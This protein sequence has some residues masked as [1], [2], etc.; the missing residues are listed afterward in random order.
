[1]E[2]AFLVYRLPPYHRSWNKRVV[3]QPKL[4][5]LD[6][7]VLCALLNIRTEQ[8][9]RTH[10]L[11]GHIFESWVVSE[12]IKHQM[13]Q[14]QWPSV[15]FWRDHSGHEI[16][17]LIEQ[18]GRLCALEVKSGE[19]VLSSW[20]E[21]MEWFKRLAGEL[22]SASAVIYGGDRSTVRRDIRVTPWR[23]VAEAL[24]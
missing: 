8:D 5:F 19:T 10:P 17:L 3:K 1:M 15:F 23:K 7:G 18:A 4:I 2:A 22:V 6:S 21:G 9:L 16:D 24:G 14:G 11:R 12:A 13:N 20:L